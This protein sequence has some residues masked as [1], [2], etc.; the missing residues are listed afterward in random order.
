MEQTEVAEILQEVH[1]GSMSPEEAL[2]KL[3]L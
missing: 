1:G 3:K 2:I